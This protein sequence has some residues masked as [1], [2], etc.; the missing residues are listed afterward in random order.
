MRNS[1]TSPSASFNTEELNYL[2][3]Q[4]LGRL[5]TQ[6]PNGTLQASP[7]GFEVNAESGTIDIH[8]FRM[9]ASRKFRNIK[10]NGKVAFVVDDLPSVDPWRVRCLEIR[11][12]AEALIPDGEDSALIRIHPQRIISFGIDDDRPP[13]ELRPSR[14]EVSA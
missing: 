13:H 9:S 3:S 4:R 11:G 14:R 7:V 10:A 5:A 8:G 12:T 1:Q 6:Q 2:R